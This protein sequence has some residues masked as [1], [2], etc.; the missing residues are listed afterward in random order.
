MVLN[1]TVLN[2]DAGSLITGI[3]VR[4][5][6]CSHYFFIHLFIYSFP[7]WGAQ[8]GSPGMGSVMSPVPAAS[9]YWYLSDCPHQ[10][11]YERKTLHKDVAF[12]RYRKEPAPKSSMLFL[13]SKEPSNILL[14]FLQGKNKNLLVI[15]KASW[16]PDYME[17]SFCSHVWSAHCSLDV[18]P[19]FSKCGPWTSRTTV[20]LDRNGTSEAPP[21]TYWTRIPRVEV[22]ESMFEQTLL[23]ILMQLPF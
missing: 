17:Y 8:L 1:E 20:Q 22:Q 14:S 23:V 6:G 15:V 3:T 16:C 13:N 19:F 18:C 9:K 4:C 7:W 21:Q 12:W 2:S 10:K 11:R 5:G